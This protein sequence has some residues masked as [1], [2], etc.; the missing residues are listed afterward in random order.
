MAAASAPPQQVIVQGGVP[1]LGIVEIEKV[2]EKVVVQKEI[3]YVAEK[4]ES[5]YKQSMEYNQAI[6]EQRN[7][8]GSQLEREMKD[9][10]A[11]EERCDRGALKRRCCI[12]SNDRWR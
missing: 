5:M 3:E 8:L 4:N 2:V 7:A 11:L 9:R 6:L 10:E 12:S 1:S